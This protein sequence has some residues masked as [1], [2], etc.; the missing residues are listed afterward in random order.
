VSELTDDERA[1]LYRA[2]YLARVRGRIG[3]IRHLIG[4]PSASR[5]LRV[6]WGPVI[7]AIA[8]RHLRDNDDEELGL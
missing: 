4:Q 8:E 2:T 7:A 3:V 6:A 5:D 1:A